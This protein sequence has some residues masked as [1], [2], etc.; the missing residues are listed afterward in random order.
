M[1]QDAGHYHFDYLK[2]CLRSLGV[3]VEPV[4][5]RHY[6]DGRIDVMPLSEFIKD[7]AYVPYKHIKDLN[8]GEHK[9]GVIKKSENRFVIMQMNLF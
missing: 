6:S 2:V 3:D 5:E 4:F 1:R 9:Y 7:E 8:V